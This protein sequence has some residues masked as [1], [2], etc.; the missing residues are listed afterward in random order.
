MARNHFGRVAQNKMLSHKTLA[1]QNFL[2]PTMLPFEC[3][4]TEFGCVVPKNR[5]QNSSTQTPGYFLVSI[6]FLSNILTD[7]WTTDGTRQSP[8]LQIKKKIIFHLTNQ[9]MDKLL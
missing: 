2:A 1:V 9:L 4:L 7:Q 3:T 6:E 8:L 5:R